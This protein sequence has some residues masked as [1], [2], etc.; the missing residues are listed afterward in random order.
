MSTWYERALLSR[1]QLVHHVLH[2][3]SVRYSDAW[4]TAVED[5]ECG[6]GLRRGQPSRPSHWARTAKQRWGS[7]SAARVQQR[8]ECHAPRP[9]WAVR[10]SWGVPFQ[11]KDGGAEMSQLDHDTLHACGSVMHTRP[12]CCGRGNVEKR[13]SPVRALMQMLSRFRRAK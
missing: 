9:M 6:A 11:C 7:G 3:C 1:T 13:Y 2:T 4:T 10:H 12:A 8:H 5:D